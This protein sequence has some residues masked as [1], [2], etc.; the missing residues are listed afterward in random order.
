MKNIIRYKS[1]KTLKVRLKNLLMWC[2]LIFVIASCVFLDGIEYPSEL[3]AN[4]EANFTM[5]VRVKTAD[6]A[7]GTRLVIAI[8]IPKSW[9]ARL[10]TSVTYTSDVDEGN[11]HMTMLGS[12]ILPVNGGGLT[13]SDHLQNKLKV[14][15]NVLNDMEWVAFQSDKTYDVANGEE[16]SAK[17]NIKTLVGPKNLRFKMGFFVNHSNDGLSSN[18]DHWKVQYSDCIEVTQG[19]GLLTDFCELHFNSVQPLTATKNDFIT[20]KYQGDIAENDLNN[21]AEVHLCATAYTDAGKAYEICDLSSKT[22]MKKTSEFGNTYAVTLWPTQYFNIPAN[23][24]P[25]SIEYS[26]TNEDGSIV[27]ED[28]DGSPYVYL[29]ECN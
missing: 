17:V 5:N 16:I 11:Q 25:L 13:W 7:S 19:E 26:F 22:L 27:I 14:G 24:E 23:E 6:A 3:V 10:H 12:D 21:A 28:N 1:K 18:T 2:L 20:F 15:P 8:L 9:E 29:F 4:Q